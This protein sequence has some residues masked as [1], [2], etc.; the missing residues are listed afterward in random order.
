MTITDPNGTNKFSLTNHGNSQNFN[1][2]WYLL[3]NEFIN[4]VEVSNNGVYVTWMRFTTN[5][6][7]TFNT[8]RQTSDP[9]DVVIFTKDS[10]FVGITSY[11][12]QNL[13]YGVSLI[14]Y[15]CLGQNPVQAV[16]PTP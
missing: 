12:G 5:T 11:S 8:G 7:A 3:T 4:K 16:L 10:P 6:G 15:T 13:I 9:V 2:N 1:Y 14:T